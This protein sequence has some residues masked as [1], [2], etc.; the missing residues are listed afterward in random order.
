MLIVLGSRNLP[1]PLLCLLSKSCLSG[2]VGSVNMCV[3]FLLEGVFKPVQ[4]LSHN[5]PG[6][7]SAS[8]VMFR[9]I[10]TPGDI[11]E[12]NKVTYLSISMTKSY[13]HEWADRQSSDFCQTIHPRVHFLQH[14]TDVSHSSWVSCRTS[15]V[16]TC[17]YL[18]SELL[19]GFEL[20]LSE[21]HKE[22]H[23]A[24]WTEGTKTRNTED[25]RRCTLSNIL[26]F[27]RQY[28]I[29]RHIT[30]SKLHY[31]GRRNQGSHANSES[32][33]VLSFKNLR[34][35]E[36]NYSHARFIYCR[37]FCLW[38][39]P[40]HSASFLLTRM[41]YVS[42]QRLVLRILPWQKMHNQLMKELCA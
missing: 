26:T 20:V 24:E 12:Q 29:L 14:E 40:V 18:P 27:L 36:Y 19:L 15:H 3:S 28:N 33:N 38:T 8:P 25:S 5:L 4:R 23:E 42:I 10:P 32:L 22:I 2:W 7:F 35:S 31:C 39:L 21:E 30:R 11:P 16:S 41:K 37:E 13:Q 6:F 9:N 1:L 17:M 34:L